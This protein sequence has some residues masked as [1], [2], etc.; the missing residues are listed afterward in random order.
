[1]HAAD[2]LFADNYVWH[3]ADGSGPM[4]RER[5]KA[6]FSLM[7]KAMPDMT[8]KVDDM[9]ADGDKVI[10]RCTITGTHRGPLQLDAGV[11]DLQATNKHVTWTAMVTHR[12]EGNKIV[13]GW[14]NYDRAGIDKQLGLKTHP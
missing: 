11:A 6:D 12:I 7:K 2:R 4:N 13:E 9:M 14:V 5:H 1:V 10:T 8:I 3:A